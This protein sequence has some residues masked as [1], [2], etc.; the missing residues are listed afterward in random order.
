MVSDKVKKEF[1][2]NYDY[3]WLRYSFDRAVREDATALLVGHSLSR[4]GVDDR[5]IPGL[6]NLSFFSQDYYYSF[7]LIERALAR[8]SSLK[9]III[10]TGYV[11]SYMDLSAVKNP[12]ELDRI[13]RVYGRYLGDIHN[14]D[15][16]LYQSLREKAVSDI[17][18]EEELRSFYETIEDDYFCPGR[19]R[20]SLSDVVWCDP[21]PEQRRF[22]LAKDRTDYHNRLLSHKKTYEENTTIMQKIEELCHSAGVSLTV[23][24]FP[25]N[26]YY[27]NSLSP[28]L[29]ADFE[30]QTGR[31]RL[32]DLF[33]SDEFDSITD[34]VD[35]DHLNENGAKRM[36]AMLRDYLGL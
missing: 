9:H 18:R 6:F 30:R 26:R 19:T 33:S 34:F 3:Y 16:G 24:V 10:G 1:F 4:F 13:V 29:K 14:M 23:V 20:Q 32:W 5:D 22:E 36:T 11:S 12:N 28:E 8:L 35:T 15:P 31:I 21:I 17:H 25:S 27:R 7:K 2:D